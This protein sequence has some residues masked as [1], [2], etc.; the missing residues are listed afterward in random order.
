MG[1]TAGFFLMSLDRALTKSTVTIAPMTSDIVS[2][3]AKLHQQAFHGYM[4]T[5]LGPAY[6]RAFINWFLH[7]VN[8]I[9]LTA[10]D[11]NGKVIGYV[12]GAPSGCSKA[13]NRDLM[14]VA[15]RGILVHPWLAIRRE[16]RQTLISRLRILLEF[17]S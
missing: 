10:T 4:S 11:V 8:T 2:E 9:N 7:N 13:L 6:I 3:V 5:R 1:T 16:F 17:S 12:L 14:W 15:L